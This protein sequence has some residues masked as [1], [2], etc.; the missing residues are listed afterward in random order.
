MKFIDWISDHLKKGGSICLA[1]MMFITCADV[2]G[3][4]FGHPFFG[5]VEVVTI[6]ATLALAMS[7][8]FTHDSKGHVGVEILVRLFSIKTQ[9]IIE[10]CTEILSF[11]L[12]GLL[13]WRMT[14]Y[15]NTLRRSGEV[16]MNLKLPEYAV[17]YAMSFCLIILTIIILKGIILNIKK[18]RTQ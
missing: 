13:T 16:T 17:V 1:V 5:S 10:L 3:R 14:L 9:T 2:V 15:A 7:L 12:F 4:A 11:C 18:L 8:P 6:M